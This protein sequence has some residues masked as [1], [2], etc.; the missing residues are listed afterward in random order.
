MLAKEPFASP[1]ISVV[2]LLLRAVLNGATGGGYTGRR[3]GRRDDGDLI[4]GGSVERVKWRKVNGATPAVGDR[5][6][7]R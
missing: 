6:P 3:R 7:S 2:A 5:A 4:Y 1:M